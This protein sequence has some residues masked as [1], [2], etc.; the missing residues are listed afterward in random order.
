M[1]AS[2]IVRLRRPGAQSLKAL[3]A[4]IALAAQTTALPWHLASE[5]HGTIAHA[6]EHAAPH[7]HPNLPADPDE[8][9]HDPA[10]VP[11]QSGTPSRVELRDAALISPALA[12]SSAEAWFA[13]SSEGR[14]QPHRDASE[15]QRAPSVRIVGPRGPPAR[16]ASTVSALR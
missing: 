1:G 5:H 2:R 16:V 3:L 9:D 10:S 14:L 15:S 4:A 7:E 6:E 12:V 8:A 11:V 13:A